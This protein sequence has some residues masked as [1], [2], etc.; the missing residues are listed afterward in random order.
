MQTGA[1]DVTDA[2]LTR[3]ALWEMRNGVAHSYGPA[4]RF[5]CERVQTYFVEFAG[6]LMAANPASW[7]GLRFPSPV[8]LDVEPRETGASDTRVSA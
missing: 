7:R 8:L 3:L 5:S 1:F 6:R 4:G 2:H